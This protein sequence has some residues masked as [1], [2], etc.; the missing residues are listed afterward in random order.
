MLSKTRIVCVV[1]TLDKLPEVLKKRGG[2][3]QATVLFLF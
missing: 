3:W 2:A 1:G